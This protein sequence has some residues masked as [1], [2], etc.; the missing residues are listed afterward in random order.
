ML[1][2]ALEQ[3]LRKRGLTPVGLDRAR[4]DISDDAAIARVFRE[5]RPTLLLNCAAHTKVDQCEDEPARA[6]A[7]NGH[8]VGKL[9]GLCRDYGT[10]MVHFSTDFVFDGRSRR[11]YRV[12]D[13]VNPIS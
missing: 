3:S 1:G 9:A 7:I 5:H 6:D 11:P 8:A 4:L 12:D 10:A 13:P 2:R